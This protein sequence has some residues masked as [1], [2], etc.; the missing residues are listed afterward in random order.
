MKK[1]I[2]FKQLKR[3]VM[4]S[5][6]VKSPRYTIQQYCDM[7]GLDAD[8]FMAAMKA[9]WSI[10]SPPLTDRTTFREPALDTY[11]ERYADEMNADTP[12]EVQAD[13][14]AEDEV[15]VDMDKPY[16]DCG[17]TIHSVKGDR[18]Y[19]M[20]NFHEMKWF[21]SKKDLKHWIE[22]GIAGTGYDTSERDR[23][24]G[25]LNQ[26]EAGAKVVDYNEVF[27]RVNES[28]EGEIDLQFSNQVLNRIEKLASQGKDQL[29]NLEKNPRKIPVTFACRLEITQTMKE[30]RR[31]AHLIVDQ[32]KD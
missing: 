11:A 24:Y 7:K 22:C 3:L 30:I 2:T 14:E 8:K 17:V 28:D 27:E 21:D 6:K 25:M 16:R 12:I 9:H 10:L 13:D 4:E 26:L 1:Q 29:G 23:F 19:G 32:M 5:P 15:E 20:K 18:E 31:L